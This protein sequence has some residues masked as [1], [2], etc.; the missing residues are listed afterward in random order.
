MKDL[1]DVITRDAKKCST[2]LDVLD[3]FL[4][5]K[6]VLSSIRQDIDN[7]RKMVVRGGFPEFPHNFVVRNSI[8]SSFMIISFS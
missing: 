8:V 4:Y 3:K 1:F 2:F 6:T 7:I 5:M